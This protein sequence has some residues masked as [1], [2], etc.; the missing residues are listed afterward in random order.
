MSHRYRAHRRLW[1]GVLWM[2]AVGAAVSLAQQSD[3]PAPPDATVQLVV[4]YGDGVEKHFTALPFREGVTV[5]DVLESA[6]R[7]PRGI[8]FVHR[9]KAATA[10]LTRID[11]LENE[12]RGRNWV[13]R[14]NG[15]LADCSFATFVLKAGDT[16]LWKFGAYR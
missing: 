12:G 16:V 4:D 13:Y 7:H 9:G 3:D 8:K 11:D 6:Q 15:E 14:V 5:L 2:C 10:F 1:L